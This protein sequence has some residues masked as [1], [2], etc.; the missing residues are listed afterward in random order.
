MA[1]LTTEPTPPDPGHLWIGLT[2][3]EAQDRARYSHHLHVSQ[4]AR[5]WGLDVALEVCQELDSID[6][7]TKLAQEP[8]WLPMTEGLQAL[9]S[10]P[11][12]SVLG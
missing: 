11:M 3:G 9:P 5:H 12:D 6:V 2:P 1:A 7:A 10:Y 4:L 8:F